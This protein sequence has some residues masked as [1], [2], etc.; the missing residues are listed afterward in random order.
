MDRRESLGGMPTNFTIHGPK[1][2]PRIDY[3]RIFV[4][5][6]ETN[7]LGEY[8]LCDDSPLEFDDLRRSIPVNGMRHLVAFYQ[9]EYAF[10]PFRVD[11]LWF[12]VLSHGVPRVEE[13]GSIGTLI[14][15][16]RVHLPPNLVPA[17]AAREAELM[18]RER[19]AELRES[20]LIR[21]E[22]RVEHLEAEV[23]VVAT[24]M[25][26]HEA[27]VRLRETRVNAL[28][29]YALQMQRAFRESASKGRLP[30]KSD[31]GAPPADAPVPSPP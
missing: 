17:L 24:K 22:Q 5:D 1:T 9:G 2:V 18:E 28:R 10:T 4:L 23:Q 16:M 15:A 14:A 20:L 21:R 8:A 25:H 7:L 6:A 13:R 19:A 27:D 31:E 29:D 11:A 30:Q 26:H 3:E 12:V